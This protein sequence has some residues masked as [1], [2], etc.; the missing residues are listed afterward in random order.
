[1]LNNQ[2][3]YI[4]MYI[5][6]YIYVYIHIFRYL[7]EQH[8]IVWLPGVFCLCSIGDDDLKQYFRG[9]WTSNRS[10]ESPTLYTY[11]FIWFGT[12]FQTM[13]WV[14]YGKLGRKVPLKSWLVV[15]NIFY[16]SIQLGISSSQLTNS[17]IFQRGRSTTNQLYMAIT[18]K[19]SQVTSD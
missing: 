1:M 12:F 2:M 10:S 15:R 8:D 7:V 17:I 6:V 3:V 14:S 4:Y 9:D 18:K 19:Y 16:F 5:Y 13:N 11:N